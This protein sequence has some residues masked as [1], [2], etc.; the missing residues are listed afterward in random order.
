MSLCQRI[1]P[2]GSPHF[3]CM[4]LISLLK[5]EPVKWVGQLGPNWERCWPSMGQNRGS[6]GEVPTSKGED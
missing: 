1:S 4:S 6:I 2:Y 5:V 3:G